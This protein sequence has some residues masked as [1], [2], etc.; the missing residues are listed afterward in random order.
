ML[1]PAT[2]GIDSRIPLHYIGMQMAKTRMQRQVTLRIDDALANRVEHLARRM[3]RG[4]SEI[5][6]LALEEFAATA[7]EQP[8]R[9]PIELVHDL[10]G[11]LEA[12]TPDLS[13]PSRQGLVKRA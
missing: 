10:V 1:T 8:S 12:S 13:H 7:P 9:R 4:R 2:P 11:R 5:I 6:R 3:R